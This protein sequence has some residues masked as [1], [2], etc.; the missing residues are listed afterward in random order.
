MTAESPRCAECRARIRPLVLRV[1]DPDLGE[2]YCWGC[3]SRIRDEE[4]TPGEDFDAGELWDDPS[5][6]AADGGAE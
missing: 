4:L 1:P 5:P 6:I 2:P 3:L